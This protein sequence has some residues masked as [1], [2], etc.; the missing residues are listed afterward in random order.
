MVVQRSRVLRVKTVSYTHLDVYKRQWWVCITKISVE[1]KF[2][3]IKLYVSK[4]TSIYFKRN[5]LYL[6]YCNAHY[7][8]V[9][10]TH[11]DVYKRQGVSYAQI[12]NRNSQQYQSSS[13]AQQPSHTT[14]SQQTD[15]LIKIEKYDGKLYG[16]H[17]K[18]DRP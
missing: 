8:P 5:S 10:Y 3:K 13:N 9:S 1:E 16:T 11:L 12:A 17:G 15:I 7:C 2:T 14:S 18:A 6:K 4:P